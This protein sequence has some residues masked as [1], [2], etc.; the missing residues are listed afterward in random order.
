MGEKKGIKSSF[1]EIPAYQ[2]LVPRQTNTHDCGLYTLSF[3]EYLLLNHQLLEANMEKVENRDLLQ[4]F[5]R[6]IVFTM[7]ECLRRLF[8]GL[9]LEADKDKVIME[10]RQT[11]KEVFES[12][13]E[14]DYDE[15]N[16]REFQKYYRIN[17]QS[18]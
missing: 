17:G 18:V 4:L 7:R 5:P 12:A 11:R 1:D 2:L 13:I 16:E 9:L 15:I 14:V 10:Y 6:S 8:S 3:I